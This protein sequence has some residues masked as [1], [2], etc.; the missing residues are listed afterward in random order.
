MSWGFYGR[1]Q[2]LG[3]LRD[4]LARNRWFF[5]RVTGRRRIGKTTLVQQALQAMPARPVFY[6]QIPDSGPAGVLSAVHGA[7]DT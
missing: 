4:I 3:R 1:E 2:E 5:V 6:V 7:M